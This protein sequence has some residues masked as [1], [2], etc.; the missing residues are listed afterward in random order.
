VEA[1]MMT[2]A[3]QA[4]VKADIENTPALNAFPNN[5][6]GNL[7][8]AQLYN[9]A[10]SPDFWV[11]RNAV[12]KHEVVGQLSRTGT[13][14]VWAGNGFITRSAGELEC[15]N[16]LFNSSLICDPSQANVRQAF[17]DIFSGAGNAALNRTHLDVV[18]RRKASRIEKLLAT[19]SG[20]DTTAGAGTMGF[21]GSVSGNDIDLARNS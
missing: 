9:A 18:S 17:A 8:I 3:Q 14:F 4:T 10:A 11:W 12:A 2:P 5:S 21:V 1:G 16:Q 13:S 20:L 15:F 7:A 19:G 6:D